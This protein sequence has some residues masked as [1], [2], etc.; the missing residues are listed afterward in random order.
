MDKK[1][2]FRRLI[3]HVEATDENGK[4]YSHQVI[5]LFD[6][7]GFFSKKEVCLQFA[8]FGCSHAIYLLEELRKH[9]PFEEDFCIDAAGHDHGTNCPVFIKKDDMNNFVGIAVGVAKKL[10]EKEVSA[11]ARH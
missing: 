11:R 6:S 8:T 9:C 7:T 1:N 2:N 3:G 5:V 10:R 4:K